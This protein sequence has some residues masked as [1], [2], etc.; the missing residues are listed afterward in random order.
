LIERRSCR[1]AGFQSFEIGVN[2]AEYQYVQGSPD[3]LGII[4]QRRD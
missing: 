3:K 2:V 4:D 1:E